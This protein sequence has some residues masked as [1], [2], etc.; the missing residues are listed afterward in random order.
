MGAEVKRT[1]EATKTR[2][3]VGI[4]ITLFWVIIINAIVIK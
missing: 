4:L 3:K 2:V 1:R